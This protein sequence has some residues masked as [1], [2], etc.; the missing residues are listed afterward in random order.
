MA[1]IARDVTPVAGARIASA[2]VYKREIL[3]IGVCENKTHPLQDKYNRHPSAI[4]L[5][6]EISVIKNAVRVGVTEDIFKRST[7]YVCRQKVDQ[8]V[9]SSNG[10]KNVTKK[11]TSGLACPCKG[12]AA[13]ITAFDIGEVIY[14]LDNSGYAVFN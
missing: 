3:A 9:V 11:W 5:H 7:L 4:F 1:T 14:S 2:L 10:R 12:C 8:T 13:A 6:S